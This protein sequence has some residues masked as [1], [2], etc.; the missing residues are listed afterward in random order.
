MRPITIKFTAI[1]AHLMLH[2]DSDNDANIL[3]RSALAG[4]VVW[5]AVLEHDKC[6]RAFVSSITSPDEV[7][8]DLIDAAVAAMCRR[9]KS[10][11]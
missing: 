10:S 1:A 11:Q 6:Q 8:R 4:K 9:V 2:G 3:E 5:R 7:P